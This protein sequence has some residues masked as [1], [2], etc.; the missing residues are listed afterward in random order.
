MHSDSCDFGCFPVSSAM[1]VCCKFSP[2]Y[3]PPLF[4]LV[5]EDDDGICNHTCGDKK[6]ARGRIPTIAEKKP[7]KKKGEIEVTGHQTRTPEGNKG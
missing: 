2:R 1:V 7:P 3:F 6:S 4:S 5:P